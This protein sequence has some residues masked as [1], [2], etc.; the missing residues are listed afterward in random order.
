MITDS[1]NNIGFYKDIIP[2][3]IGEFIS[4]TDLTAL[5]TGR[6]EISDGV[7]VN[8]MEYEP[9][10]N[11]KYEAHRKYADL[12]VIICGKEKMKAALLP[13]GLNDSNYNAEGDYI[14]FEKCEK[15]FAEFEAV[16]GMFYYFAPQDAHMP[17]I[18]I[19]EGKVKK[20]VFKIPV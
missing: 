4:K 2:V 11:D 9:A 10:N 14:L 17:S 12:Q 16:P 8:V 1:L 15:G 5:E 18:K 13:C 6:H 19:T 3:C 7:Y 20:A